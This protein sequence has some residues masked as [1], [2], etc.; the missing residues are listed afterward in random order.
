MMEVASPVRI[1]S[2]LLMAIPGFHCQN[3]RVIYWFSPSLLL[4]WQLRLRHL[5]KVSSFQRANKCL[6]LRN[7]C[8]PPSLSYPSRSERLCL[9]VSYDLSVV[10]FR[11]WARTSIS[12]LPVRLGTWS[13]WIVTQLQ[14]PIL[15]RFADLTRTQP[16]EVKHAE[17]ALS[18]IISS[19]FA[20]TQH[21]T[22]T[23]TL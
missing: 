21:R 22:V 4:D 10:R 18:T 2:G 17:A 1:C 15:A 13:L 3:T 19:A 5:A 9:V 14:P 12:V 23:S 11:R 6:Q 20:P 8:T 16:I 7:A